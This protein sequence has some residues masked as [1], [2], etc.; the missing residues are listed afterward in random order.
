MFSRGNHIEL[1]KLLVRGNPHVRS[2]RAYRRICTHLILRASP[3]LI[4]VMDN[5]EHLVRGRD[6]HIAVA[7]SLRNYV[8]E[9]Q[10]PLSPSV[11]RRDTVDKSDR[12]RLTVIPII[13]NIP[14]LNPGMTLVSAIGHAPRLACIRLIRVE[15]ALIRQLSGTCLV[16]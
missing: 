11:R 9:G 4:T 3:P 10:P 8:P 7:V 13:F 15:E 16:V 14:L 1:T 5:R 2:S 6:R 12:I